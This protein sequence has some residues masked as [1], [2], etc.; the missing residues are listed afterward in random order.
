M[1]FEDSFVKNLRSLQVPNV[2]QSTYGN[3]ETFTNIN[4]YFDITTSHKLL[5]K[6]GI[7]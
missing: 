7:Y 3:H 2:K 6:I 5:P 1:E 4:N